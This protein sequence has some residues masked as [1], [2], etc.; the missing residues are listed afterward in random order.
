MNPEEQHDAGLTELDRR[1]EAAQAMGG[2]D[3]LN[4]RERVD[5]LVDGGSFQE[6]GLLGESATRAEDRGRTPADGKVVGFAKVA[7]REVGVAAND[8]TVMGSSSSAT[9]GKKIGHVKRVATDR[10]FPLIFLGESSGARMPD[11]MGSRGMG[12]LLGNDGTQYRR[13]RESPW[14]SATL[15]PSYGSSSWYSVLS[16]FNVMRKGAVLAVSSPLLA[17]LAM[18]EDIDPEK[19]EARARRSARLVLLHPVDRPLLTR[20]C[21]RAAWRFEVGTVRASQHR[22]RPKP[23]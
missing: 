5:Y 11:H 16:D 8:F 2:E 23:R 21:C 14:A 3:K 7:G 20:W 18:R 13:L 15:G 6:S 9:N 22:Q 4:A 19:T 12:S 1:T 10:G 17:A